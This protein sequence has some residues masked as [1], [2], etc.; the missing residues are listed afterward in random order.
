MDSGQLAD[1]FKNLPGGLGQGGDGNTNPLEQM[2][3]GMGGNPGASNTSPQPIQRDEGESEEHLLHRIFNEKDFA[4]FE[5]SI[6]KNA[7]AIHTLSKKENFNKTFSNI[8]S[9]IIERVHESTKKFHQHQ[10]EI[11][12]SEQKIKDLE[13]V[14]EEKN[15]TLK[16]SIDASSK[17][18]LEENIEKI[19]ADLSSERKNL[20]DA[21]E[22]KQKTIE[23]INSE[24]KKMDILRHY[25]L[26]SNLLLETNPD[27]DQQA[28]L[29]AQNVYANMMPY[30]K[31]S[32]AKLDRPAY[33]KILNDV[34]GI[35]IED[36]DGPMVL[37]KS[38]MSLVSQFFNSE[39]KRLKP[40]DYQDTSHYFFKMAP[41][42]K[43]IPA[44]YMMAQMLPSP[45]VPI[46]IAT[47][48]FLKGLKGYI[49]KEGQMTNTAHNIGV[50][51]EMEQM[52]QNILSTINSLD[53]DIRDKI[54]Q[55]L[56]DTATLAYQEA[57][58]VMAYNDPNASVAYP[59]LDKLATVAFNAP[60]DTDLAQMIYPDMNSK[61]P[62]TPPKT[63]DN[64]SPLLNP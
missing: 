10:E 28:H 41:G 3:K 59:D 4:Q 24:R 2:L 33:K 21:K 29:I 26:I 45:A 23:I 44:A 17:K 61:P 64:S 55:D 56:Q 20:N 50:N 52:A 6:S 7:D 12:A 13:K 58:S 31:D 1:L 37:L 63:P 57:E 9:N 60:V 18:A 49:D 8:H 27:K 32:E 48:V 15:Q 42:Q 16:N 11:L 5:A 38:M 36:D 25:A 62:T 54:L 51:Q 39:D 40:A 34:L 53:P 43:S 46:L 22:H 35:Q 14:A 47:V 30:Y 19:E